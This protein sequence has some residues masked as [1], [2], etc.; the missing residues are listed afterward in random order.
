MAQIDPLRPI[1]SR[2]LPFIAGAAALGVALG[3]SG[4]ARK[5]LSLFSEMA[6]A[7]SGRAVWQAAISFA[8]KMR[9]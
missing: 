3:Y 9:K 7:A 1:E 2:P 8:D 6:F 5:G 4:T